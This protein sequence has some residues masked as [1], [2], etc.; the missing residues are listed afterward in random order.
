VVR[1]QTDRI[2]NIIDPTIH[3][4]LYYCFTA[5]KIENLNPAR[6]EHFSF[7]TKNK[8]TADKSW[9]TLVLPSK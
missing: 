3:N 6:K 1:N 9:F 8:N 2:D 7:P 5:C 4:I